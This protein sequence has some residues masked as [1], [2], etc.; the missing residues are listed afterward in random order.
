MAG[1]MIIKESWRQRTHKSYE[2]LETIHFY[3][4]KGPKEAM[5]IL[6]KQTAD[7]RCREEGFIL[8]GCLK[9][10][11]FFSQV[12]PSDPMTPLLGSESF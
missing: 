3:S 7:V 2:S 1:A 5:D 8:V 10:S 4:S 12:Q 9:Q 11:H 6:T